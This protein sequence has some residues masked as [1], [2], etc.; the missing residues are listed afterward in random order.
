MK[1]CIA[2]LTLFLTTTA[3]A[4]KVA[5]FSCTPDQ[6]GEV[7]VTFNYEKKFGFLSWGDGFLQLRATNTDGEYHAKS[8][9]ETTT[10][11]I[12]SKMQNGE[13][14]T[15]VATVETEDGN[16]VIPPMKMA[17]TAFGQQ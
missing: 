14:G 9:T 16:Q 1:L 3:L 15:L 11:T 4:E 12:D 13:N 8:S 6:G 2:A 7:V 5:A 10:I 17:C